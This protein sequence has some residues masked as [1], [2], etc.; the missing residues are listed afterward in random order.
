M[1]LFDPIT[2]EKKKV[3]YSD[4]AGITG[5]SENNLMTMKCRGRKLK[6]INCYLLDD[7]TTAGDLRYLMEIED[8]D[9]EVW[10]PIIGTNRE[11]SSYGRFRTVT[12]DGYKFCIAQDQVKQIIVYFMID[13]KMKA[14][15]RNRIVAEHFLD[16]PKLKDM[17]VVCMDGNRWN[18][19][20]NNLMWMTRKK[21]GQLT[22]HG[23]RV[24]VAKIDTTTG[25]RLTIYDSV[26]HASDDNYIT[27]SSIYAV[28]D[29]PGRTAAGFRWIRVNNKG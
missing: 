25:K 11:V 5:Y 18:S 7:D 4:L 8:I 10:R 26:V 24:A 1:F 15:N 23:N 17:V 22:G 21:L 29:K 2:C 27:R 13:G 6:N 28:L 9:D 14:L 3:S 20:A 12:D 16:K 19:R